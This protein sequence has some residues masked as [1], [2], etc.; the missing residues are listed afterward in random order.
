MRGKRRKTIFFI[1]LAIAFRRVWT[2]KIEET[3]SRYKAGEGCMILCRLF[4]RVELMGVGQ[5]IQTCGFY[6]ISIPVNGFGKLF[7]TP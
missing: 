1:G 2:L 7:A 4:G 5:E 6:F 3:I